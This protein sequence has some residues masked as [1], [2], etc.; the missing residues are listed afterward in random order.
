MKSPSRISPSQDVCILS[1]FIIDVL[2]P[3]LCIQMSYSDIVLKHCV[4]HRTKAFDQMG[5]NKPVST[6]VTSIFFEAIIIVNTF[7]KPFK[8]H[9][10]LHK[11]LVSRKTRL[12]TGFSILTKFS[13]ELPMRPIK[14][15]RSIQIPSICLAMNG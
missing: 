5:T 4:R 7:H 9:R 11:S 2:K 12:G 13:I 6:T 14:L 15:R 10:Q 8:T 1:Y 3:S